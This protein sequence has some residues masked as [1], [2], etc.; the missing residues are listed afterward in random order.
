MVTLHELD[1]LPLRVTDLQSAG[2]GN[3]QK[4]LI[5]FLKNSVYCKSNLIVCQ[6]AVVKLQHLFGSG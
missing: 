1:F 3:T 6:A 5:E 4:A 2:R